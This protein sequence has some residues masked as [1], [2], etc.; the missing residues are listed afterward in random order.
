MVE[1]FADYLILIA[2]VGLLLM[3]FSHVVIFARLHRELRRLHS[4]LDDLRAKGGDTR[5][6]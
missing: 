2:L 3:L 6:R 5:C 1:S 4:I